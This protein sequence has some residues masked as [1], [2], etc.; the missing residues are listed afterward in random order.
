MPEEEIILMKKSNFDRIIK[1]KIEQREKEIIEI[2]DEEIKWLRR[3]RN[4][5]GVTR[6]INLKN[7]IKGI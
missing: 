4:Y 2:I 6:L 3:L 1:E 7:K 5:D